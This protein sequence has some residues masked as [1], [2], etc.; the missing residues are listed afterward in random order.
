[1]SKSKPEISTMGMTKT[2]KRI[3]IRATRAY[4]MFVADRGV[5]YGPQFWSIRIQIGR[6]VHPGIPGECGP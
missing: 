3:R 1:M 5:P 2:G 6:R 4:R